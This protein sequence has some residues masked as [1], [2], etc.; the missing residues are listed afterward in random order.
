MKNLLLPTLILLLIIFQFERIFAG[1][2]VID[3]HIHVDQFGYRCDAVKIAVIS[4]PQTGYNSDDPFLPGTGTNKYE[5][6]RWSDDVAVF[7]GT[8][9]PWNAGATH[10]NRATRSGGLH[11]LQ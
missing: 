7:T 9:K 10:S 11:S 2:T 5:V 8:L 6:R 4:N 1:P 3:Y